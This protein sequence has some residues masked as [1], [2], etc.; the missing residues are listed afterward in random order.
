MHL[1]N[2]PQSLWDF[3]CKWSC[4]VRSKTAHV[5]FELDGR[6]PFEV[7]MGYTPDISSLMNYDFYEPIW[8][9]NE[10][11]QFPEPKRKL[12]RWLGEAHN[13]GQAM[14]YFILPQSGIPIAWSSVQP[15]TSEEKQTIAVQDELKELDEAIQIKCKSIKPDEVSNFFSH[16]FNE[17]DYNTPQF[18]PVEEDIPEADNWDL[19]SYDKYISAQVLLPV[20]GTD[21]ELLGT[22]IGCKRDIHGN[23]VGMANSNPIL[24]DKGVPSTT[25]WW[26]HWR[27]LSQYD[28]RMYLLA[29]RW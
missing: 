2:V 24:D 27:I 16:Q 25:P 3:Y 11:S 19:E 29:I 14:S 1:W 20:S 21:Q 4:D 28:S 7:V 9:Y 23:P 6:T 15:I 5:S 10:I 12:A 18:E 26:A 8:Y 13:V 17:D 22:V